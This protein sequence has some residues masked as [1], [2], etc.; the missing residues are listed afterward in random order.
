MTL[1]KYGITSVFV[2]SATLLACGGS[3][4][5]GP[6]AGGSN[7]SAGA[8]SSSAGATASSAGK[9]SGGAPTSGGGSTSNGT[10]GKPAGSGGGCTLGMMD[11]EAQC[12]A[13]VTCLQTKCKSQF[14]TAS[15]TTGPCGTYSQC[16]DACNCDQTCVSQCAQSAECKTA[17]D[18]V[19]TC[20]QASCITEFFSCIGG[21]AGGAG[22]GSAKT[23]ADLTACCATL[24]DATEKTACTQIAG[25][26]T[27]ILCGLSY[28]NFCG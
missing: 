9:G 1:V 13:A 23:C 10:G 12:P 28:S 16:L 4:S 3:D 14:D 19:A 6:T 7:S 2:A 25:V 26:G 22:S 24:T 5:G 8:S 15:S 27:E 18:A 21:G 11:A 20:A 17:S